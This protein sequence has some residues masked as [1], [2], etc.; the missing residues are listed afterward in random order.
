MSTT[1]TPRTA[2]TWLTQ[3]GGGARGRELEGPGKGGSSIRGAFIISQDWELPGSVIKHFD[4]AAK[5]Q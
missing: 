4:I 5:I 3:I 2:W 1:W